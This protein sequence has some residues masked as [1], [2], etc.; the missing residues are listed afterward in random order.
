MMKQ[1]VCLSNLASPHP[2]HEPHVLVG[3]CA[4]IPQA[5][6]SFSAFVHDVHAVLNALSLLTFLVNSYSSDKTSFKP[7]ALCEG[8]SGR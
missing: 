7:T 3:N 5:E 6:A 1:L 4:T 2:P 8:Y